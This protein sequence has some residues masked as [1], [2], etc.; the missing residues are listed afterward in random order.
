M[1]YQSD[2]LHWNLSQIEN[3]G[4]IGEKALTAYRKISQQLNV[5]M[6]PFNT[7]EDRIHELIES[8][9]NF[10][11]LSRNLAKRAQNRE[12]KTIQPKEQLNGTKAIISI[13]NYL[14]GY[15]YFTTDETEIVQDSIRLIEGKHSKRNIITSTEDIKDGLLKM[16][17]FTNL[18][19]VIIGNKEY[20]PI[21]TLKL[22]SDIEFS[23]DKLKPS[24]KEML[25]LLYA[26]S[27][28][29]NFDVFLNDTKL[30]NIQII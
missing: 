2:P 20:K 23:A 16:I 1:N 15:Y 26:E 19:N 6:H 30:Q 29:D 17:L 5:E 9:E 22:T 21:P 8:K 28:A 18:K 3:I 10:I 7:A 12:R 24:K 11:N 14:G 27:I 13:K 4:P 25:R